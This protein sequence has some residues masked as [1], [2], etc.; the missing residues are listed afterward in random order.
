VELQERPSE[1][2]AVSRLAAKRPIA[3]TVV[4]VL[5]LVVG[6][7][8]AVAGVV[9]LV[10]GGDANKLAEGSLDLALGVLAIAIGVGALRMGRWAWAA[11]MTWAVIGLTH[12]LLRHFFYGDPNHVVMALDAVVVFALTPLDVQVAFGVRSPRNLVLENATRNPID[13]N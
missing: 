3:V 10:N 13:G 5:A 11:F 8:N 2:T 7:A 12:Q 1:G 6:T 9:V 4:G